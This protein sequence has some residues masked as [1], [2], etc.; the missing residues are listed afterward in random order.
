MFQQIHR[1]MNAQEFRN[2]LSTAEHTVSV[3]S[4]FVALIVIFLWFRLVAYLIAIT[5]LVLLG[6]LKLLGDRFVKN[7]TQLSQALDAQRSGFVQVDLDKSRMRVV[8]TAVL[9]NAVASIC[10]VACLLTM[11]HRL[12]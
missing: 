8:V 3:A 6:I 1:Y 10:V 4:G 5:S 9:S 12:K 7:E 2:A 11:L